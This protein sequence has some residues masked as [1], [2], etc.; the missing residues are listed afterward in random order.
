M[1]RALIA[2]A[3][4]MALILATLPSSLL[5]APSFRE[6]ADA[7]AQ[8][9]SVMPGVPGMVELDLSS[10]ERTMSIAGLTGAINI[11]VG[12]VTRAVNPSDL[13]TPAEFLA[14]SQMI[15]S[16]TQTLVL[17]AE[18]QA[19][20]GRF[21]LSPGLISSIGS[22]VIPEGVKLYQNFGQA[23]NFTLTGNLVNQGKLVAFSTS[24]RV[25]TATI[26]AANIFNGA[27]GII[28]S[29]LPADL[30][31]QSSLNLRLISAG[32][33]VNAGT[34]S[35]S[36]NL[37]LM[38][39]GSIVNLNSAVPQVPVLQAAGNVNLY[40]GSGQFTNSGIISALSGNVNLAST[41]N[42]SMLVNNLG[43]V[44]QAYAGAI[45]MRDGAFMNKADLTLQGGD[46]L[47]KE[48]NLFSG[49][50]IVNANIGN[51]SGTVN[52]TSHEAHLTAQADMLNLGNVSVTGD[53]TFFNTAAGI[54]ITGNLT[55]S[56]AVA[57]IARDNITFTGNSTI[58]ATDGGANGANIALVA[59]ANITSSSGS[60]S[61]SI[62]P[63]SPAT[64]DVT[65]S[66]LTPVGGNITFTGSANA[67]LNA[68][69]ASGNGNGGNITLVAFASDGGAGG[70]INLPSDSLLDTSGSGSG[71]NG[72]INVI[73]G[74]TGGTAITLG[75]VQA[76]S[77]S[78]GGGTINLTTAQPVFTSGTS[79]TFASDG[80]ISSGNDFAPDVTLENAGITLN[81]NLRPGT[82]ANIIAGGNIAVNHSINVNSA[83]GVNA[84]SI[85]MNAGG[86]LV[87]TDQIDARPGSNAN[88]GSVSLTSGLAMTIGG[89]IFTR[90]GTATGN[91]GDITLISAG[92]ITTQALNA[93]S[94][95]HTGNGG[96]VFVQADLAVDIGGAITASGSSTT[97]NSGNVEITS[98]NSSVSTAAITARAAQSGS[99]VGSGGNVT[100]SAD[101]SLA[102]NGN[103]QT[104]G[105]GLRGDS[106][107]VQLVSTN[108]TIDTNQ[109][110]TTAGSSGTGGNIDLSA[111][112]DITISGNV[113]TTGGSNAG[114]S[115]VITITS[116]A[117]NV[118]TQA[119]T[120][121][122]GAVGNGGSIWISTPQ[123]N[124]STSAIQSAGGA[125][126]GNGGFVALIAGNLV[127]NTLTT[128]NIVTVAGQN[129]N[130]GDIYLFAKTSVQTGNINASS[131]TSSGSPGS[132]TINNPLA[133]GSIQLGT[134][135]ATG[136]L[137]PNSFGGFQALSGSTIVAGRVIVSGVVNLEAFQSISVNGI[138]TSSTFQGGGNVFLQSDLGDSITI[139][140][141]GIVTSG[142]GAGNASGNI[143]LSTNGGAISVT[144]AIT[145]SSSSGASAGSVTFFGSSFTALNQANIT[146]TNLGTS[147]SAGSVNIAATGNI[148]ARNI[149]AN[150]GTTSGSG[151]NIFLSGGTGG[152]GTVSA[153]IVSSTGNGSTGSGGSINVT[154]PGQVS[155][156]SVTT[157]SSGAQGGNLVVMA[158]T[159]GTPSAPAQTGTLSVGAINTT[160]I[161]FGGDVI[162]GNAGAS[163]NISLS[164][165]TTSATGLNGIAGSIGVVASGTVSMGNV[166][167]NANS[168]GASTTSLAGD[169]FVSS[170]AT[171]GTGI[172]IGTINLRATT[173]GVNNKGGNLYCVVNAG[174][175]VN[176]GTT[177]L[178]GGTAGAIFSGTPTS[179]QNSITTT[180]TLSFTPGSVTGF[181]PGGFD[182]INAPAGVLTIDAVGDTQLLVPVTA[183]GGDIFLG[184]LVGAQTSNKP[185]NLVLLGSG[186]MTFNGAITSNSASGSGGVAIIETTAGS[187]SLMDVDVS[188]TVQGGTI[189]ILAAAGI[190]LPNGASILANSVGN[191]GAGG[192][193]M[194]YAPGA[195]IVLGSADNQTGN[196]I[197]ASGQTG[198]SIYLASGAELSDFEVSLLAQ[199]TTGSGGSLA[200]RSLAAYVE[201][202]NEW[203][204]SSN[205]NADIDVSSVSSFG[206]SIF[207]SGPQAVNILRDGSQTVGGT[208][209]A[210]V[211]ANGGVAGGTIVIESPFFAI[212]TFGAAALNANATQVND[213]IGGLISMSTAGLV[214]TNTLSVTGA[215]GGTIQILGAEYFLWDGGNLDASGSNGYGGT[216]RVAAPLDVQFS[217]PGNQTDNFV[218]VAGTIGGGLIDVSAI[219][220]VIS[221]ETSF[222]ANATTGPGGSVQLSS[223]NDTVTLYQLHWDNGGGD[224]GAFS[225]NIDVSSTS[226]AGGQIFLIGAM[227]VSSTLDSSEC[228]GGIVSASFNTNGA[229]AGGSIIINATFAGDVML[230]ELTAI[231]ANASSGQ[232]GTIFVANFGSGAI[233]STTTLSATGSAGGG[234][235]AAVSGGTLTLLDINAQATTSG[236]G[237]G[238]YV[239]S[240]DDLATG[241]LNASGL[242]ASGGTILITTAQPD[243]S[244]TG[245]TLSS[246][247]NPSG[248]ITVASFNVSGSIAGSA[249]MYTSGGATITGG[250]GATTDTNKAVL[251]KSLSITANFAISPDILPGGGLL[252]FSNT[253][254]LTL[255]GFG[256]STLPLAVTPGTVALGTVGGVGQ[257]FSVL[258]G[259]VISFVSVNTS[260][261]AGS[262]GNILLYTLSSATNTIRGT[263]DLNA[264]ASGAGFTAGR[265]YL[266][267]PFG[268]A[269]TTGNILSQGNSSAA[270]NDVSIITGAAAGT[271][272]QYSIALGGAAAGGCAD[273]GNGNSNCNGQLTGLGTG[274]LGNQSNIVGN[275]IVFVSTGGGISAPMNSISGSVSGFASGAYSLTVASGNLLVD[276]IMAKE[277]T[278]YL[279]NEQQSGTTQ[280]SITLNSGKTLFANNGNVNLVN[281]D[282]NS[283]VIVLEANSRIV[284][285]TRTKAT[286]GN[287]NVA[288]PTIPVSPSVGTA[289]PNTVANNLNGGQVYFNSA[290]FVTTGPT[291]TINAIGANVVFNAPNG[292][293]SI[294]MNGGV[295]ITADPPVNL[296]PASNSFNGGTTSFT[297]LDTSPNRGITTK[298]KTKI[299]LSILK[300]NRI[301]SSKTPVSG[302]R[303]RKNESGQL[304]NGTVL[305]SYSPLNLVP[306]VVTLQTATA[307]VEYCHTANV[308]QNCH[309]GISL[310]TGEMLVTA[311]DQT[312]LE[313]DGCRILME[314][315][316]IALVSKANGIL[317]IRNL[318]DS[319]SQSLSC[320]VDGRKLIVCP[321]QELLLGHGSFD[322][323][324]DGVGRRLV[325]NLEL[326]RW[327]AQTAEVSLVS[328]VADVGLLNKVMQ[329]G[330]DYHKI[331]ASKVM[332]TGACLMMVTSD[333]GPYR[334]TGI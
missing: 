329:S 32:D 252:S 200:I 61:G 65:I 234:A 190:T 272:G 56:Q 143:L 21:S 280:F 232:G 168:D 204:G 185:T 301:A 43:G 176:R 184:G 62:P 161:T 263:G 155:L 275:R 108:S 120:T 255:S 297:G 240:V 259:G 249:S 305:V 308:S 9:Q 331:I 315:D 119:V 293:N 10:V 188:G 262:G 310:A 159:T 71:V 210:T 6:R 3:M 196:S 316:T 223:Y 258:A 195:T 28:T 178:T 75:I 52:V 324:N 133:A 154:A 194:L 140:G 49:R 291:N 261:G 257:S 309:G 227:G 66:S 326:E 27:T 233:S 202:Y 63:G 332:R 13:L 2:W 91:S 106:G 127:G 23:A 296:T 300:G 284:A 33:I 134:V 104:F 307:V 320:I 289:P 8:A 317:K 290:N 192:S 283:G 228:C 241:A 16:G 311:Y 235:I 242:S 313:F 209:T 142:V 57:I 212:S 129:G 198:G 5:A 225:S 80:T 304:A 145:T 107:N 189:Q 328:L 197:N 253:A 147:G 166:V 72:N 243:P 20:R 279:R 267:A 73:A 126:S 177:N 186:D 208:N 203:F 276:D 248:T 82:L 294:T 124:I 282:S 1:K 69:G 67:T 226:A 109:I 118:S 273:V 42:Q 333:H 38:A 224:A 205:F 167:A 153:L 11:Q 87:A 148:S 172:T 306:G 160:G 231:S 220:P 51:A 85:V 207:I 250:G 334:R 214:D 229:T 45:N 303:A 302:F 115:G 298:F 165:L 169:L 164:T 64:G 151:G 88:G 149:T 125:T 221:Y 237:G 264:S 146:T 14:A 318:H 35:S 285:F 206:G 7:R 187:A 322:Q 117:G 89:T 171:T 100:I 36:G 173:G 54:N 19:T 48:L 144:G 121:T 77:S 78:G 130:G 251:P 113:T 97:G 327:K 39:G 83:N 158:G 131:G 15:T 128:N 266:S 111:D 245:V 286:A 215:Y 4:S 325:Q 260:N 150:G 26:S 137:A 219:G 24:P 40:A 217:L 183:R 84:G 180:T 218:S 281:L 271:G 170:G 37:G 44:L 31:G 181:K 81:N 157:A 216:I 179:I 193:V 122:T 135:T 86:T 238:I 103:I 17:G 110:N 105:G 116:S 268:A 98:T 30:A 256:L 288:I 25:N 55:V 93:A 175:T 92:S 60:D 99:G 94:Q 102:L 330:H 244:A 12:G 174:V 41:L 152:T 277:G 295:S 101:Q 246:S 29:F 50:G 95:G 70:M 191:V 274:T 292:G 46:Y 114:N 323:I 312:S 112:L 201:I 138:Q 90:G 68:R 58:R 314:P 74:A 139:T 162:I 199:G 22:L 79:M 213:S 141:N 59:G 265:I 76:N 18:G 53:P 211:N 230:D 132:I 123:G 247:A 319:G 254:I 270:N 236:L 321:G 287:V 156:G 182:S 222:L 47:S 34:I 96:N 136:T 239:S 163:G 299:P 278:L 269:A